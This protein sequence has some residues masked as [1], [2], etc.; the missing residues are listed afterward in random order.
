MRR[1]GD[2]LSAHWLCFQAHVDSRGLVS[3]GPSCT[4]SSGERHD[5][6]PAFSPTFLDG[7]S[8]IDPAASTRP[9]VNAKVFSGLVSMGKSKMVRRVH[10][11]YLSTPESLWDVCILSLTGVHGMCQAVHGR[12]G[13]LLVVLTWRVPAV[14]CALFLLR[15]FVTSLDCIFSDLGYC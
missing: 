3:R 5:F 1:L 14:P 13:I 7:A 2:G 9:S 4:C 12:S 11:S 8:F 15:V 10:V 6:V